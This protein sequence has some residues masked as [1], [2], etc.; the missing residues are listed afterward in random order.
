[1]KSYSSVKY[2]VFIL[3]TSLLL[4]DCN[5]STNSVT[6]LTIDSENELLTVDSK[7][8]S[9]VVSYLDWN[10]RTRGSLSPADVRDFN[11]G[12]NAVFTIKDRKIINSI[13]ES[14]SILNLTY[15]GAKESADFRMVMDFYRGREYIQEICLFSQYG[16][17]LHHGSWFKSRKLYEIMEAEIPKTTAP[18]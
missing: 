15:V 3:A 7:F 2:C 4:L 16:G 9:I 11:N 18:Y 8:D 1:M 12:R 14:L 5:S 17:F 6:S 13:V 10:L